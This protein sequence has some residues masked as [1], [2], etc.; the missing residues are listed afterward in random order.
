MTMKFMRT[1]PMLFK[2]MNSIFIKGNCLHEYIYED[3]LNKK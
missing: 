1:V 2:D 3:V